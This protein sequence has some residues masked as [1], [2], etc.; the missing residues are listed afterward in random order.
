MAT[1]WYHKHFPIFKNK[2]KD[3]VLEKC[4]INIFSTGD[5]VYYDDQQNFFVVDRLKE[6]IKY[7]G[8]QVIHSTSSRNIKKLRFLFHL[9]KKTFHA[10]GG[11]SG[12]GEP[13]SDS[14]FRVRRGCNWPTRQWGWRAANGV[15]CNKTAEKCYGEWVGVLCSRFFTLH[16]LFVVEISFRMVT[17]VYFNKMEM[18]KYK[19]HNVYLITV[20]C[21]RKSCSTQ[22]ITGRNC[23][24]EWN[25]QISRRENSSQNSSRHIKSKANVQI[26]EQKRST[27]LIQV[28]FLVQ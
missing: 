9:F 11:A 25:P 28:Q 24:R 3:L 14:S 17:F 19:I 8:F 22:K 10:L 20:I 27:I 13:H 23:L 7:K 16:F 12:A 5:I 4:P 6:L 26:I 15:C 18:S 2:S 1:H 21:C